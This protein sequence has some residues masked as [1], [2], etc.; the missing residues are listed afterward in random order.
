MSGLG[1]QIWR[2]GWKWR[3]LRSPGLKEGDYFPDFSLKDTAGAPHGIAS[4]RP[5]QRTVLWFTN[6]CE[7]CRSKIP[8][9]NELSH[10]AGVPFRILSISILNPDDPLPH[11]VS[12]SCAFPILLDPDDIV[13]RR[14]GLP[15]PPAAC[16]LHNFFIL[17]DRGRIIF[18]HH[19]SVLTPAAF[20]KVWQNL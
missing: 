16:P 10:K 20:T 4:F 9:L 14:L 17:D 5:G 18:R 8:L 19:L 12:K 2:W 3:A 1:R 13:G 7:D 15:H 11:E 6:L